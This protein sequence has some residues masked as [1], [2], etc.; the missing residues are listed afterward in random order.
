MWTVTS[1]DPGN[2]AVINSMLLKSSSNIEVKGVKL[3]YVP[4]KTSS[5]PFMIDGVRNVTINAVDLE[6]HVV[7]GYGSGIGLRVKGSQG[8]A[9]LNSEVSNFKNG[10]SY[11]TNTNVTIFNNDFRACRPT[12]LMLGGLVQA[13]IMGN[14]FRAMKSPAA[15]RTRT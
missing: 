14:D 6:G 8:V 13:T 10:L 15:D 1:A 5:T 11:S 7:S 12:R 4:S 3:D 9:L 2:P